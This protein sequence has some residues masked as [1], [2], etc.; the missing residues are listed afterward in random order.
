[1]ITE[2]E[3]CYQTGQKD[4]LLLTYFPLIDLFQTFLNNSRQ[5]QGWAGI[6]K[7]PVID[8]LMEDLNNGFSRNEI[9]I[10]DPH[11]EH[12]IAIIF[13]FVT[14]GTSSFDDPIKIVSHGLFLE[15]GQIFILDSAAKPPGLGTGK[16][17]QK[18]YL[19]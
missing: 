7:D 10:C 16:S 17:V 5:F 6:A 11:G 3:T 14:I 1:M 13:P 9:H 15:W 18:M 8:P 4:D 2:I 19:E 12:I